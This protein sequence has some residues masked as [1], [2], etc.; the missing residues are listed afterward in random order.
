MATS[1]RREWNFEQTAPT[2]RFVTRIF[3]F[4]NTCITL[5]IPFVFSKT[6]KNVPSRFHVQSLCRKAYVYASLTYWSCHLAAWIYLTAKLS[7]GIHS[8]NSYGRYIIVVGN[9][10]E[11]Q[12]ESTKRKSSEHPKNPSFEKSDESSRSIKLPNGRNRRQ[13]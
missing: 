13:A 7:F 4:I 8:N 6:S 5:V 2:P 1:E 10:L 11:I 9:E 12:D 3:D